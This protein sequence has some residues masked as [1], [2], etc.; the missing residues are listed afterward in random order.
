VH[1]KIGERRSTTHSKPVQS[2]SNCNQSDMSD[3]ELIKSCL[4]EVSRKSGF[5]D[6]ASLRQR[7]LEHLS[8]EIERST[9]I[10][11]S[12]STIKRL[13]NGQF[14]RL[15]QVATLN[16]ISIYLGYDSWQDFKLK[17]HEKING[18]GE[19]APIPSDPPSR[20][21]KRGIPFKVIALGIAVI[22]FLMIVSYSHFSKPDTIHEKDISFS[23]KKIT[24]NDIPNTVVF[25]YDVSK[26]KGDSFFIQ[27]SWDRERRVRIEKNGH[28][29]TDIYYEPGYHNA[30]L[31]VDTKVVKTIDVSIPTNGWFFYSKAALFRGLP[32]Y[33][34]P[35]KP[36]TDGAL[37]LRPEDITNSKIDPQHENFYS[38]TFFPEKF[39]VSSDNFRFKGRIRFKEMNNVMCPVI[40]HEICGQTNALYFFTTLP[41]CTGNI[42]ANVGEH[43]MSGKTTDL[44]GF[45]CDVRQ[46]HLIEVIVKNKEA[47]FYVDQKEIFSKSYTKSAGLITGLIFTANGLCELDDIA[48]EGLDGKI[49]YENDFNK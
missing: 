47:R 9:G 4:W 33:I 45:G 37:S 16:A 34:H 25:T 40:M 1:P 8:A 32:T 35:E 41:G 44:S 29:L 46:W 17:G 36:V 38:Y 49:V 30:K 39:N 23:V 20:N 28:T 31:I 21:E 3:K 7:D 5:D 27:Q 15:P 12:V 11:I 10:L 2:Y 19:P 22:L 6:P 24:S 13:L 42:N 26:L 43:F 48:V 18:V 14:N